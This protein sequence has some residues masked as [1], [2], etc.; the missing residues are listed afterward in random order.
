[1]KFWEPV[2]NFLKNTKLAIVLVLYLAVSSGLSTLVPQ[3]KEIAFYYQEFSPAMAWLIT[4][5]QFNKFFSSVP[6]VLPVIMFFLNLLTCSIVRFVKRVRSKARKRF[7]PDIIHFGILMLMVAVLWAPGGKEKET[8]FL[9]EGD[10]KDLGN[11]YELVLNRFEFLKYDDGRPKDWYSYVDV[12]KDGDVVITHRIEVN[13]PLKVGKLKLFQSSYNQEMVANV[14]NDA[15]EKFDIRPGD[16]YTARDAI[17]VF[18]GVI[19]DNENGGSNGCSPPAAAGF[20]VFEEL[21]GMGQEEG[22]SVAAVHR[23]AVYDVLDGFKIEKVCIISETG[24][25][26]VKDPTTTP[27]MIA[28]ILI[29]LGI[30]LTFIQKLGDKNL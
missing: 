15:G 29:G 7:G 19:I 1:M 23:V 12:K 4:S 2:Y 11:G 13:K 16:Y 3:G 27:V 26:I 10:T 8:V 28:M 25:Q 9:S 24:L 20:A 22:H 30:S 5:T 6:F 18:K 14:S 21:V 17:I